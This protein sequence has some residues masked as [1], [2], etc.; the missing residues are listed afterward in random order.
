MS[1]R[2]GRSSVID[3]MNEFRWARLSGLY[4]KRPSL[5]IVIVY[6]SQ[7]WRPSSVKTAKSADSKRAE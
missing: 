2:I 4:R 3:N 1:S 6:R 7:K 5:V